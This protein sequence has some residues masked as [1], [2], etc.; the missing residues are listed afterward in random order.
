MRPPLQIQMS[1]RNARDDAKYCGQPGVRH[2]LHRPAGG[3]FGMVRSD[4][5]KPLAHQGWDLYAAASTPIVAIDGRTIVSAEHHAGYGRMVILKFQFPGHPNGLYALY[6]HLCPRHKAAAAFNGRFSYDKMPSLA[7]RSVSAPCP[8]LRAAKA[9][10]SDQEE[11][12]LL[13]S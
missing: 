1:I 5:S 6:G 13:M 7:E 12:W 8:N 3:A 9:A 2:L 4:G 10:I 11:I